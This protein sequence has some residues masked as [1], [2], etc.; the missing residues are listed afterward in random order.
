MRSRAVDAKERRS[1][2]GNVFAARPGDPLPQAPARMGIGPGHD[3]LDPA[4]ERQRR[5]SSTPP[6]RPISSGSG[7]FTRTKASVPVLDH[8]LK[9]T[10]GAPTFYQTALFQT[11]E[12]RSLGQ[13]TRLSASAWTRRSSARSKLSTT[14]SISTRSTFSAGSPTSTPEDAEHSGGHD[15]DSALPA[16]SSRSS[17]PRP[18]AAPPKIKI[19]F[20]DWPADRAP[21]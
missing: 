4:G 6:C 14:R 10:G 5:S 3:G 18:K 15:P 1:L 12:S 19:T 8:V 7:R 2:E 21:D 11:A 16:T 20:E 17:I 13:R 9:K